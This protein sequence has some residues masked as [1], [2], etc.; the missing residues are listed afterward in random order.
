[1]TTNPD[2]TPDIQLVERDGEVTLLIDGHQAMQAWERDLMI[3]SADILCA[4]GSSFLEVGLGLGLSALHIARHPGTRRHIVVE[5]HQRVI[6]LFEERHP[7]PPAA[8]EIV[9]ADIFDYIDALTPGALDGIFF[10]P[11]LPRHEALDEALWARVMPTIVNALRPGGVFVP[12]FTTRPE[13]KW[14]FYLYFADVV[15][16]RRPFTAYGSTEYTPGATGQA[17][18]Q[19]FSRPR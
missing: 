18:I 9:R 15:V 17:Y 5:K 12:F 1:M 2:P 6:D 19:C 10:D 14:P 16:T 8:L 3:A 4:H 13:L 11:W 7:A